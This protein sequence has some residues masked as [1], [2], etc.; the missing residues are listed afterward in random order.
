MMSGQQLEKRFYEARQEIGCDP[1][2]FP[3]SIAI[4]MDGNGRWAQMRGLPRPF[5]HKEGAKVVRQIVKE[6]A[7][8]G[9]K[10]LTLYSFSH[11]NWSR[12]AEEVDAL[13]HLFSEYL[14]HER[15]TVM[16]N[17]I[18]LRHLGSRQGLPD[19]VLHELDETVRQ[20][21][22]NTGMFLCLALN[23]GS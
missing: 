4:I 9:L 22:K 15:E 8:L 7:R 10:A 5:G 12:P 14:A 6:A 21:S 19:M 3:E 23:Y 18:R 1:M 13:M 2:K 11:Q 17:N 16:E 20:S